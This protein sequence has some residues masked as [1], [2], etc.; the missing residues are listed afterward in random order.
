MKREHVQ[1]LVTTMMIAFALCIVAGHAFFRVQGYETY[2]AFLRP[3]SSPEVRPESR[4]MVDQDAYY[5][6]LFTEAAQQADRSMLPRETQWDN[7]PDG[8]PVFWSS[9]YAWW[10][11]TVQGVMQRDGEDPRSSMERAAWWSNPIL[12]ML[13]LVLICLLCLYAHSHAVA[14]YAAWGFLALPQWTWAFYPGRA[15]HHG[16][17]ALAALVF[18]L[19]AWQALVAQSRAWS[20]L[21]ALAGALLFWVSGTT[22]FVVLGCACLGLGVA[23][24]LPRG[25]PAS[26]PT[27]KSTLWLVWG[28]AGGGLIMLF[29]IIEMGFLFSANVEIIH[30]A[31]ALLW[32][33][34][35]AVLAAMHRRFDTGKP[36]KRLLAIGGLALLLG[37]TM[38]GAYSMRGDGVFNVNMLRMHRFIDEFRPYPAAVGP[39]FLWTFMKDF[40][41]L[42]FLPVLLLLTAARLSA[43]GNR[44]Q[45]MVGAAVVCGLLCVAMMAQYRWAS[46]FSA[47]LLAGLVVFPREEDSALHESQKP[48]SHAF[49][50]SALVGFGLLFIL[51]EWNVTRSIADRHVYPRRLVAQVLTRDIARFIR[52]TEGDG[53]IR[54]LS[55]PTMTPALAYHGGIE[56]AA[57]LYWENGEGLQRL[58]RTALATDF[59]AA[60]DTLRE[61]G[62]T[63]I[64]WFTKPAYLVELMI[65]RDGVADM[66]H[67]KKTL[68]YHWVTGSDQLPDRL[69]PL[70]YQM[71][72]P[73]FDGFPGGVRLYRIAAD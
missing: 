3:S 55:N 30:P 48:L 39:S 57:S 52:E 33:G 28:L 66:E 13:A 22:G 59:E 14:R 32:G 11:R 64:I 10:L 18:L 53:T 68:G 2:Q 8:R 49:F 42:L 36:C 56:G 71:P 31:H 38:Y 67:I 23:L 72:F 4:I 61:E 12:F 34:A 5:W 27:Q 54:A 41:A 21:S 24:M 26:N 20:L 46:L 70:L 62:Y 15:D 37:A 45:A 16:W 73:A 65:I 17:I 29:Y 19:A 58:M 25:R 69:I 60:L 63:H 44:R 40:G 7:A 1:G 43:N 35:G 50:L 47:A 6:V 51:E 9:P